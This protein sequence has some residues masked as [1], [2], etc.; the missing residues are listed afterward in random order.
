[1][2]ERHLMSNAYAKRELPALPNP[3]HL[4][5]QAKAK[6]SAL[7]LT[8][9]AVQLAQAQT[10]L[11]EEY[12]FASWKALLAEVVRR[13]DSLS[14]LH[15][16]ARRRPVAVLNPERYRLISTDSSLDAEN[17]ANFVRAGIIAQ[18]GFISV[19]LAGMAVVFVAL[20]QS[21]P[22]S[23]MMAQLPAPLADL[24]TKFL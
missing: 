23:A 3:E 5:K 10:I 17:N 8:A 19:A 12:G 7:R 22:A 13:A 9:S 11:A 18:V 6:L 20:G 15:A 1:M 16:R 4:R 14:G 24:I 2:E 21:G